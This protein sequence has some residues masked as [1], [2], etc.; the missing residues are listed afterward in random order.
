MT[1]VSSFTVFR[2]NR[3][4]VPPYGNTEVSGVYYYSD[5]AFAE[6][7]LNFGCYSVLP[8]ISTETAYNEAAPV[9]K[10]RMSNKM[11]AAMYRK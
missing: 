3:E 8:A 10:I 1:Q 7:N 9:E 5:E 4:P 11:A 2:G 6:D